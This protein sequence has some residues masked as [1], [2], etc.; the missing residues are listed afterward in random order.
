M[1]IVWL[2]LFFDSNFSA[3]ESIELGFAETFFSLLFF[4]CGG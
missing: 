2:F 4:V 1:L 3:N